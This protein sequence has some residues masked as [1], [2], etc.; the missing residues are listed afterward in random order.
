M[1]Q[2][3]PGIMIKKILL[4]LAFFI[5]HEVDAQLPVGADR[6][7]FLDDYIIDN[8]ENANKRLHHPVNEGP[9][10]YFDKPW[11][12]NFSAY[13]TIIQDGP[14]YKAY[15]RGVREAGRDG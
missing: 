2:S 3:N 6:Q 4:V 13:C 11:E 12:G 15:Y 9:V 5:S 14:I 7:L 1:R 8:M 10:L